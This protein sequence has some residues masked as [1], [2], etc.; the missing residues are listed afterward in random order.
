[1]SN[2]PALN[3]DPQSKDPHAGP[4]GVV[5]AYHSA[6][7]SVLILDVMQLTTFRPELTG[8]NGRPLP[9]LRVLKPSPQ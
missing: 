9:H 3:D 6:T 7:D 5:P 1:M 4:F 2:R 8:T